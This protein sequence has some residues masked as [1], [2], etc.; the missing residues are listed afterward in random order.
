M[1]KPEDPPA[2]RP[3]QISRYLAWLSGAILLFGCAGL[4][5][6]DVILRFFLNRTVVESFEISGYAFAA[7]VALGMAY[8]VSCKSNIRIDLL[9][10]RL[11]LRA[12]VMLDMVAHLA[13]LVVAATIAWYALQ[14]WLQSLKL[15]AKSISI[16]QVPLVL[17][18]GI[19]LL[20]LIWF[21][22]FAAVIA[23]HS[24]RLLLRGEL[25]AVQELIGPAT[26]RE[27]IEQAGAPAKDA[28]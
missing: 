4:I 13:I 27:E 3:A 2:F 28:G 22:L 6:L 25:A 12:R 24:A 17:P 9:A 26:L 8:T 15:D 19:W 7:A 14:T 18:Q 23:W 1:S 21:A 5:T 11:P 10:N 16:L 20:G